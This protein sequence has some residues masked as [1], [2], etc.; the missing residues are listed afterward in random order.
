V[1]GLGGRER[2]GGSVSKGSCGSR[3]V[4]VVEVVVVNAMAEQGL[5]QDR[6]G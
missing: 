3:Q 4:K 1:G 6:M 2:R 5:S